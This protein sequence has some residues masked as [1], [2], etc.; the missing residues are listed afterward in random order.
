[1]LLLG[2][3]EEQK[4]NISDL[5]LQG[6]GGTFSPAPGKSFA[7]EHTAAPSQVVTVTKTPL[8]LHL[9]LPPRTSFLLPGRGYISDKRFTEVFA[10][11]PQA[12]QLLFYF[13]ARSN[14]QSRLS[15]RF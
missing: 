14:A 8:D 5:L 13:P 9:H 1:M 6:T 11:K 15:A 4:R 12:A 3:E 7:R 2:S 10:I